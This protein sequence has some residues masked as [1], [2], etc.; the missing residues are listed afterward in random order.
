MTALSREDYLLN[1]KAKKTSKD[2]IGTPEYP[3]HR[4]KDQW[5]EL[6]QEQGAVDAPQ[7]AMGSAA[8]TAAEPPQWPMAEAPPVQQAAVA[9]ANTFAHFQ[10]RAASTGYSTREQV[11]DELQRAQAYMQSLALNLEAAEATESCVSSRI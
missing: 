8:A 10:Q 6:Q 4:S 5:L 3:F 7:Q 11:R 2:Q 9:G 1:S